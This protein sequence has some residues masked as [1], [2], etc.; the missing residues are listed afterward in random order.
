MPFGQCW[1]EHN[2]PLL[3]AHPERKIRNADGS[4]KRDDSGRYF[5]NLKGLSFDETPLGYLDWLAGQEWIRPGIFKDRLFA[6]LKHPCIQKELEDLFPDPDDDSRKPAFIAHLQKDRWHGQIRHQEE[7]EPLADNE[8]APMKP[9]A[10]W[11][12]IADFLDLDLDAIDI[13]TALEYMF[14]IPRAV[15]AAQPKEEQ[16]AK[17]RSKYRALRAMARRKQTSVTVLDSF[18]QPEP[19]LAPRAPRKSANPPATLGEKQPL[20]FNKALK[21][22]PLARF[23]K[24]QKVK[25]QLQPV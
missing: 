7:P 19:P 21:R 11:E 13:G 10:A 9:M 5:F 16:I 23:L 15:K 20:A 18:H 4:S 25:A 1:L 14:W 12:T 6:Y 22:W 3:K 8:L 24:H 17:I 2:N